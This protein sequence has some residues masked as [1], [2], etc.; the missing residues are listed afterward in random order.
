M[1]AVN[2]EARHHC[3]RGAL[4]IQ[5]SGAHWTSQRQQLTHA[6][7]LALVR[8]RS[9]IESIRSLQSRCRCVSAATGDTAALSAGDGQLHMSRQRMPY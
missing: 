9:R 1:L 4:T 6:F 7:Q 2:E 5:G 8:F 3:G